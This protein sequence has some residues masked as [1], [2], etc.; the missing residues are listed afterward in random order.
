MSD[1]TL[2]HQK[3][4]EEC[5]NTLGEVAFSTRYSTQCSQCEQ[6]SEVGPLIPN[7]YPYAVTSATVLL[8]IVLSVLALKS[9]FRS[10]WF[11]LW[12]AIIVITPFVCCG[13]VARLIVLILIFAA[14]ALAAYF[15]TEVP[16]NIMFSV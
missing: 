9:D 3:R 15:G 8:L 14:L 2:P 5:G 16:E 4:C 10:S 7:P 11:I 6:R 12:G 13:P 1:G